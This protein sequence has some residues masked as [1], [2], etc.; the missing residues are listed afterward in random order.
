MPDTPREPG[1]RRLPRRKFLFTSGTLAGA[2]LCGCA[3]PP[4]PAAPPSSPPPAPAPGPEGAQ[5]PRGAAA[6]APPAEARVRAY[7]PLGRT[8]FSVS[9]IALGCGRVTEPNVV[10]YAYDH[11]VNFFDTAEGYGNGASE[12]TIGQA[13]P[14]LE[15]GKVFVVTKLHLEPEATAQQVLDRFAAC[16]GRLNTGYVDGLYLHAATRAAQVKHPGFHAAAQQLKAAGKVRFLGISCHGPRGPGDSMQD[17][18]LAA[19]EDGRFDLMLMVYNFLNREPA[20]QVLAA[21]KAR[22]IGAT[23]MKTMPAQLKVEPVNLQHLSLQHTHMLNHAMVHMGKTRAEAEAWLVERV[24]REAAEQQQHQPRLDA[25]VKGQRITT[26]EELSLQSVRWVLANP[27]VSTTLISMNDFE[28]LERFLALSGRPLTVPEAARL[29]RQARPLSAAY[30]RQ[31][32]TE[33]AAACPR[34]VPVSKV[35]RY[36]YYDRQGHTQDARA[37][38]ARLGGQDGARCVGCDAP[39]AGACPH[40]LDIPAQLLGAHAR[41]GQG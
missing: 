28:A 1:S 9:D 24:A 13:L 18:L 39:C 2:A 4:P 29:Q 32:C 35:M 10:R 26:Q 31:G 33:C 15:R 16:L 34:R 30:C 19:A 22:G 6:A 7:R 20:E 5:A 41:L 25:F 14:H 40:G 36:A 38:Y 27:A 8:G 3:H 23:L 37:R 12:R 21:C 11:G 17:V